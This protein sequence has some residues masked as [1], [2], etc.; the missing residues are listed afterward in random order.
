MLSAVDGDPDEPA[1]DARDQRRVASRPEPD[2]V[3]DGENDGVGDTDADAD[4]AADEEDV[5]TPLSGRHTG[6]SL[7]LGILGMILIPIG[8]IVIFLAFTRGDRLQDKTSNTLTVQTV[9]PGSFTPSLAS[10]DG[11]WNIIGG[12]DSWVG[13][14]VGE[15]FLNVDTPSTAS[16]RTATVDG[17]IV[18]KSGT[19]QGVAINVL[20]SDLKSDDPKRDETLRTRGLETDKFPNASFAVSE[21]VTLAKVP[22]VGEHLEVAIKGDLTLHGVTKPVAI[23]VQ[24]QVLAGDPLVLEI[25]ANHPIVFA[26]FGID[27]P[28]VAGVVS[29]QDKAEI[30]IHLHLARVPD[31][32]ATARPRGTATTQPEAAVPGVL[33]G[34]PTPGSS[35]GSTIVSRLTPTPTVP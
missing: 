25:V 30:N 15:K 17:G 32:V 11:R 20:L 31:E 18:L 6:V 23:N 16:A 13:Y 27:P 7:L 24:V 22:P 21:P 1:S 28:S 8:L 9:I 29:V 3:D 34:T 5:V 26:D 2:P 33:P 14:S 35:P 10:L 19:L 12:A 4:A